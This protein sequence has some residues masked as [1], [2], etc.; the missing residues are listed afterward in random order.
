MIRFY[1]ILG[2]SLFAFGIVG[3]AYNYHNKTQQQL[4][5]LSTENNNLSK[6]LSENEK[7]ITV[8]QQ[9]IESLRVE[10]K[11]LDDNFKKAQEQVTALQDTLSQ[12]DLAMLASRKPKLVEI[13]I[14]KAT[15]DVNRC[16]EIL[17]G[18]PLTL[19]EINATKSS[20][21]NG[22]CPDIANPNY[23]GN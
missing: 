15:A 18:K 22:S 3:A 1:I 21:I 9:D 16:I 12:H 14:N 10:R 11:L 7:T 13:T 20:E 17:S 19:E 5:A 6:A 23:N 4:I 2:I 8:L